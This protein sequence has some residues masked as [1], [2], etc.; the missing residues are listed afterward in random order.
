MSISKTFY[1][2]N[3]QA[4]QTNQVHF[5]NTALI[6]YVRKLR[7]YMCIICRSALITQLYAVSLSAN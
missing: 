2:H 4:E 3:L 1:V 6:C 7:V 5:E